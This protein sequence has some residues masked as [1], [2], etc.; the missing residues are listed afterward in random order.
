M[1]GAERYKNRQH[2]RFDAGLA[3]VPET[4]EA[5]GEEKKEDQR[6]VF[7]R[8]DVKEQ[9]VEGSSEAAEYSYA[10][11]RQKLRGLRGRRV[12][13]SK[14]KMRFLRHEMISDLRLSHWKSF[15]FWV[16]LVLLLL[17][18]WT[19]IYMHYIGMPPCA[20]L[21]CVPLIHSLPC[22]G[23][24]V[25]LQMLRVPVYNF[26]A[27]WYNCIVKYVAQVIPMEV[28]AAVF[29]GCCTWRSCSSYCSMNWALSW[30]GSAATYY[31][32]AY[33]CLHHGFHS[34]C[35]AHSLRHCL[36]LWLDLGSSRFLIRF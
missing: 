36:G 4:K 30:P 19:R 14:R 28:G 32:F 2:F 7:H 15:D 31:C 23:Q 9:L 35:W 5:G 10:V 18:F 1:T 16:Q 22:P 17:A 3:A 20:W 24:Y 11:T 6:G 8:P 26:E 21:T 25:F 33:L 29:H 13:E 34:L 12:K 27:T